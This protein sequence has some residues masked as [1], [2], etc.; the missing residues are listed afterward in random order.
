MNTKSARRTATVLLGLAVL[1]PALAIAGVGASVT[2]A[3][4]SGSTV[5][6]RVANPDAVDHVVTVQVTALSLNGPVTSSATGH[7]GGN[8]S[9]DLGVTFGSSV[10]AVLQ[11][12]ITS[13]DPNPY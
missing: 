8:N 6:V 11:V 7:V 5:Q 12:G 2:G 1:I 10:L 13:D 3:K 9:A 4:T